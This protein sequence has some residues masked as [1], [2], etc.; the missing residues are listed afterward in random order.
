MFKQINLKI[1]LTSSICVCLSL[2]AGCANN[3]DAREALKMA[4]MVRQE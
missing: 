2:L 1:S 4:V 3:P